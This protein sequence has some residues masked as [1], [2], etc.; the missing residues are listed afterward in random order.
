VKIYHKLG[1]AEEVRRNEGRRNGHAEGFILPA[2]PGYQ[3]ILV[4]TGTRHIDAT[5]AE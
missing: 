1:S 4:D 3:P 2:Q 5:P